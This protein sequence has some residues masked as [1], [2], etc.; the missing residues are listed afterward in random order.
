MPLNPLVQRALESRFQTPQP[1]TSLQ[2]AMTPKVTAPA[3]SSWGGAGMGGSSYT[4]SSGGGS[5][6]QGQAG[7]WLNGGGQ[8]QAWLNG[9]GGDQID[10]IMRTI[11][12]R[13]SGGGNPAGNYR[14][15]T[16]NWNPNT[17]SASGAYQ[18]LRSTWNNYGGYA[19]A[20]LAPAAVQDAK[21]REM[22]SA[23]LRANG[24]NVQAVPGNWFRPA[25]YRNQASWDL[26]IP[27]NH[28]MTM[29]RYLDAW[30]ADYRRFGGR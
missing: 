6:G 11:R 26:P 2:Q 30:L 18:F 4:P 14:A 19:H 8:G 12:A 9:G 21:A 5:G 24:G 17:R 28:G 16:D 20:Y 1:T 7:A 10:A 25:T 23:I 13:E 27:G 3:T 29:R 15:R 22:I